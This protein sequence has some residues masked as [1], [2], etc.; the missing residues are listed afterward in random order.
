M[1]TLTIRGTVPQTLPTTARLQ[2]LHT[3]RTATMVVAG[4][5][6]NPIHPSSKSTFDSLQLRLALQ[7]HVC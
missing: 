2:A 6:N 4:L 5:T 7:F 1:L 3:P